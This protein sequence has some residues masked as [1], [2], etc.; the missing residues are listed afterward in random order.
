M[1]KKTYFFVLSILLFS[2]IVTFGQFYSKNDL[3]NLENLA[4]DKV[5]LIMM[6]NEEQRLSALR[7]IKLHRM[8]AENAKLFTLLE[9][10]LELSKTPVESF[11]KQLPRFENCDN[12]EP[13]FEQ[14]Q[15]ELPQMDEK[16]IIDEEEVVARVEKQPELKVRVQELLKAQ[17]RKKSIFVE[18]DFFAVH[19]L[20]QLQTVN[21]GDKSVVAKLKSSTCPLMATRNSQLIVEYLL[22]M[23]NDIA[24]LNNRNHAITYGQQVGK[25]V[26]INSLDAEG[27][28]QIV[29]T[30]KFNPDNVTILSGA[31][32]IEINSELIDFYRVDPIKI[33]DI[34]NRLKKESNFVHAFILGTGEKGS[35]SGAS[36]VSFRELTKKIG[37]MHWVCLVVA[38]V[39]GE[40]NWFALDSGKSNMLAGGYFKRIKFIVTSLMNAD[41][42]FRRNFFLEAKKQQV[43][44]V[45]VKPVKPS[46]K[47][48][49]PRPN[50]NRR[51][52]NRRPRGRNARKASK[53][54]VGVR[55]KCFP[56]TGYSLK[57]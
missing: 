17:I 5:D 34:K 10:T 54:D 50:Q 29:K 20:F 42:G 25:K 4:K 32:D 46:P 56:G 16:L 26:R 45:K 57:D 38:K 3:E 11:F 47:K 1:F 51:N 8:Q 9:E 55:G 2:S 19:N 27:V 12:N 15:F 48:K 23:R 43:A 37:G 33:L 7:Y 21:Q 24:N 39:D 49:I 44:A 40:F 35:V 36:N 31:L 6:L 28:K 13:K 41:I 53:K 18:G 14:S 22:G 52:V 30:A